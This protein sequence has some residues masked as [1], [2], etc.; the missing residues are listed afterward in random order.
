LGLEGTSGDFL[1]TEDNNFITT[2]WELVNLSL[3]KN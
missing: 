2:E 1:A 3:N